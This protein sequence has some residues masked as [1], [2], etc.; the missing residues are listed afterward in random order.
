MKHT[1]GEIIDN[2]VIPDTVVVALREDLY[3]SN[4]MGGFVSYHKGKKL[5]HE[6][7]FIN[8]K[9]NNREPIEIENSPVGGFSI[10]LD[11]CWSDTI[12]IIDPR[13]FQVTITTQ[14]LVE[15]L[16]YSEWS[17]DK[18]LVGKFL[19]SWNGNDLKLISTLDPSYKASNEIKTKSKAENIGAK[20]LVPGV[21]Y[22]TDTS[23]ELW[24]IG[25]LKWKLI[26]RS[27]IIRT[28]DIHTFYCEA[29]DDSG[30]VNNAYVRGIRSIPG[31][32][33]VSM[34]E[35]GK[36]DSIKIQD[37]TTTFQMCHGEGIIGTPKSIEILEPREEELKRLENF[38]KTGQWTN[39]NGWIERELTVG[40][41]ES[42]TVINTYDLKKDSTSGELTLTPSC[43]YELLP[44]GKITTQFYSYYTR[45][46]TTLLPDLD[47]IVPMRVDKYCQCKLIFD[48]GKECK[49][50]MWGRYLSYDPEVV[51]YEKEED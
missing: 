28:S 39:R 9:D 15:I 5:L 16:R 45:S 27:D 2:L 46:S 10:D 4:G 29:K 38:K 31:H 49:F 13:G 18:G 23:D 17:V 22:K 21:C 42:D 8:F 11:D 36:L 40:H 19:Y 48:G 34:P 30:I 14:N 43:R 3:A 1:E 41:Q 35:R 7:D 6:K 44:D 25:R 51:I 47:K 37:I 12:S 24:Y 32:I 26:G 20:D 33:L 50:D